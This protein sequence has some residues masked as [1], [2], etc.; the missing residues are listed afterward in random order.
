MISTILKELYT[1]APGQHK[2]KESAQEDSGEVASSG[3]HTHT[4]WPAQSIMHVFM[5][6]FEAE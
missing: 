3:G 4:S 2:I 5:G 6:E 1:W